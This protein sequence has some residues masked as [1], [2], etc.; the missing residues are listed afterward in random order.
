MYARTSI[1]IYNVYSTLKYSNLFQFWHSVANKKIAK[2]FLTLKNNTHM[3]FFRC[4]F[5]FFFVVC[6]PSS[7][8]YLFFYFFAWRPLLLLLL[9]LC[10]C[11]WFSRAFYCSL[12]AYTHFI[13]NTCHVLSACTLSPSSYSCV[14]GVLEIK[15][16]GR[17]FSALAYLCMDWLGTQ[18]M[19]WGHNSSPLICLVC[20]Q[21]W[22]EGNGER[23][24]ERENGRAI[25][26]ERKKARKRKG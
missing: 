24:R 4:L 19:E 9:L 18:V 21:M 25:E 5:F 17:F 26:K 16:K 8:F 2:P 15:W 11:W 7:L 12:C 23:E 3:A 20:L 1:F 10:F 13:I 6:C 22:K 14:Y